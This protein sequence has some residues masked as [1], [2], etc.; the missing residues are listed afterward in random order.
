MSGPVKPMKENTDSSTT[1]STPTSVPPVSDKPQ[2]SNSSMLQSVMMGQICSQWSS[3]IC[4]LL[5]VPR[6]R[7][8]GRLSRA[9]FAAPGGGEGFASFM[10]S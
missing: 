3:R 10:V 1:S 7:R 9:R 8:L 6:G 5:D 4:A 2:V